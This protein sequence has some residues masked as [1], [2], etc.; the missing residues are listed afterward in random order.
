MTEEKQLLDH[1]SPVVLIRGLLGE[2]YYWLRF[3]QILEQTLQ[4]KVVL[5]SLREQL[6]SQTQSCADLVETFRT[7]LYEQTQGYSC[8]LVSLSLGANV[9]LQWQHQFSDEIKSVTLINPLVIDR[10][11][12][13]HPRLWWILLKILVLS[14]LTSSQSRRWFKRLSAWP[15]LHPEL[16]EMTNSLALRCEPL[17]KQIK[18]FMQSGSSFSPK[19]SLQL[20]VSRHDHWVHSSLS[21]ALAAKWQVPLF[22]HLS[23][24][25]D[26][27]L[28]DPRWVCEKLTDWVTHYD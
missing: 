10:E 21:Y 20:L 15:G 3:Q 12:R 23:A 14:V 13:W 11:H 24:G 16:T 17:V 4:R 9:A 6:S 27:A 25:H 18:L 22:P 5:V 2:N 7:Q 19:G 1:F 8:H 26:L 28:D